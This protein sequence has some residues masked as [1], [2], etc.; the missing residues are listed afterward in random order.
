VLIASVVVIL[1][2][3]L[4]LALWPAETEPSYQGKKLSDWLQFNK[5]PYPA[6]AA[7]VLILTPP[8]EPKT[9][10]I[11]FPANLEG[12]EAVRQIGTNALPF[13]LKW[14]SYVRPAW[15]ARAAAAYTNCPSALVNR[16][17]QSWLAYSKAERLADVSVSAF[18]ILGTNAA[19][20]VPELIQKLHHTHDVPTLKRIILSLGSVGTAAKE[21]LP[22]LNEFTNNPASRLYVPAMAAVQSI[23]KKWPRQPYF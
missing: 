12:Q 20:A 9:F 21:A 22:C 1:I 5:D 4:T 3:I 10:R 15:K 18:A 14:V 6:V 23:E 8:Y 19:P 13:L 16:S 2:T 17:L 11:W 7:R